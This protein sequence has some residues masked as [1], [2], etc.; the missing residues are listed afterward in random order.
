MC[1]AHSGLSYVHP[2]CGVWKL[3]PAGRG[4]GPSTQAAPALHLIAACGHTCGSLAAGERAAGGRLPAAGR[5]AGGPSSA[6]GGGGRPRTHGAHTG[7]WEPGLP[8]PHACHQLLWKACCGGS[9]DRQATESFCLGVFCF[10]LELF[11]DQ[12]N[13][14]HV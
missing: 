12:L 10:V 6:R 1:P 11:R 13:S 14:V 5:K 9:E 2:G 8:P 4:W 3:V 7:R